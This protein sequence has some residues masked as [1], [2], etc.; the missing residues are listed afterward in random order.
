MSPALAGGFFTTR[1]TWEAHLSC[2]C[3]QYSDSQFWKVVLHKILVISSILFNISLQLFCSIVQALSCV[4]LFVT[5]WTTACQIS[6]SFTISQSLLNFISILLVLQS[7]HLIPCHRLLLL[8]SIF[9]SIRV[10]SNEWALHSRWS[11]Y[12]SFSTFNEYSELVSFRTDW[13][14][15]LAAYLIRNSLYTSSSP[16]LILCFPSSLW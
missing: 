4:H 5:P 15:L 2:K 7:N 12:W 10:F 16:T 14:D 1:A 3:V 8:P 13:F 11:K 9:L 6:L